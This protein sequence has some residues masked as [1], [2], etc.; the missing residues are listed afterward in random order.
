MIEASKKAF[1]ALK[2]NG[3]LLLQDKRLANLVN[4]VTGDTPAGSWWSHPRSGLVFQVLSELSDHPDV[5]LTKLVNKKVT[6]VHRK[7]WPAL[8]TIVAQ[9]EPWQLKGLSAAAKRLLDQEHIVA[10]G[11]AVKEIEMRLLA[12]TREVHSDSGKHEVA[13]Q[14][15]AVW[16]Q[17]NKVKPLRSAAIAKKQFER[18]VE[19]IGGDRTMLPWL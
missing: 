1:A 4:V 10:S 5:L 11:A 9:P 17:Q 6:L 16:A 19:R 7:L 3:L 2:D 12:H 15:W 13:V 8:W 14:P 18:A